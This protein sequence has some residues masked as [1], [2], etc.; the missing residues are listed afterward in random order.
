MKGS[1]HDPI[2]LSQ[3]QS[4]VAVA[5]AS[6]FSEAALNLGISQ[7]AVSH[8]ISTLEERLGI[9]LF[10]RGRYGARLTPVGDRVLGHAQA[11]MAEIEA[12]QREA[13]LAK[14]L[15]EGEVRVATFRSI[16]THILPGA[17]A[18]FHPRF[19]GI[20]LNLSEYDSYLQVEQ[21]LKEGRADIGLTILPVDPKLRTWTLLAD[22]F[23]VLLP[24]SFG[25]KGDLL[26]WDE[27]VQQ[28]LIM[29]PLSD[30][31]MR[32]LY[33]HINGLGYRLQV[34]NQVETD[35]TIVSLVAQGIGGTILPR[36]AEEPIP[37]AVKVYSLPLPLARQIGIAVLAD[38]MQTP[39][40]YALLETLRA[41]KLVPEP[42][43]PS[44]S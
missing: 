22:E 41:F 26:T 16:A 21:A 27:L 29:P 12:I 18:Q 11:I 30:R 35:A 7:S 5:Q 42:I 36:L 4:M 31:M 32:P 19:P 25:A 1:L 28:P 43:M 38:A 13:G 10:S 8:A 15:E 23:V 14:G 3:L 6:S 20:T 37:E 39:A 24:P 2:K 34:V 40:V 9:I 17:I 44:P 33:E